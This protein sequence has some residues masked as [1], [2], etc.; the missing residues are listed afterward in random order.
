AHVHHP[1]TE[2]ITNDTSMEP[3]T[4]S[5][6]GERFTKYIVPTECQKATVT[7]TAFAMED[8]PDCQYQYLSIS[9][10]PPY[11][12]SNIYCANQIAVGQSFSSDNGIVL[13]GYNNVNY[14]GGVK[15]IWTADVKFED[16]PG[17]GDA[18]GSIETV[19]CSSETTIKTFEDG[20]SVRITSPTVREAYPSQNTT[21]S[22]KMQ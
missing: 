8:Y 13:Y 2:K 12:E 20:E 19:G 15:T 1:A 9:T 18:G 5:E 11:K 16:I 21:C 4:V 10:S 14:G 7:F 6:A 3:V 17:C 22:W